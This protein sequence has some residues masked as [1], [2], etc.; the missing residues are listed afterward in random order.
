MEVNI[1]FF[2]LNFI[3]ERFLLFVCILLQADM[4]E[5]RITKAVGISIDPEKYFGISWAK[6]A[7]I[8]DDENFE[9]IVENDNLV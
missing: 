6:L 1:I 8:C 4:L 5:N 2:E 7:K 3:Q 9:Y